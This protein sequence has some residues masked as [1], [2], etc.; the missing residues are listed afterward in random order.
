[1]QDAAVWALNDRRETGSEWVTTDGGY[2]GHA[3]VRCVGV[4]PGTRCVVEPGVTMSDVCA[5]GNGV[6]GP[7]DGDKR[8][9]RDGVCIE[10]DDRIS[11]GMRG[12]RGG[13]TY[14]PSI[15]AWARWWAHSRA[16]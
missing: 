5:Q 9:E 11:V 2:A 15:S 7:G 4:P 12:D 10:I 6:G 13:K 1:M 14:G 3:C 16:G 8:P